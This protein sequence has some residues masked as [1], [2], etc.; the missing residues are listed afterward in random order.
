MA[1]WSQ[2]V[3]VRM[4]KMRNEQSFKG[5]QFSGIMHNEVS[6]VRVLFLIRMPSAREKMSNGFQTAGVRHRNFFEVG[7]GRLAG[8]N[9][10]LFIL[11]CIALLLYCCL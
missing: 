7:F 4:N 5:I 1:H 11:Y 3:G 8:R 10:R 9:T 2:E 6:H